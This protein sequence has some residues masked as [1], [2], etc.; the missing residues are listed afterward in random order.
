MCDCGC[1]SHSLFSQS[2]V[3][4]IKMPKTK[5]P[6]AAAAL[7]ALTLLATLA[8]PTYAF[9]TPYSPSVDPLKNNR[10][11]LTPSR[12]TAEAAS[13]CEA[14]PSSLNMLCVSSHRPSMALSLSSTNDDEDT[15]SV[16]TEGKANPK[17]TKSNRLDQL[18][19]QLTSAFPFFVLGQD[20]NRGQDSNWGQ[21]EPDSMVLNPWY[22]VCHNCGTK[23]CGTQNVIFG[24][25]GCSH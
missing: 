10:L 12:R 16:S 5:N 8:H 1:L 7:L 17:P 22:S 15:D 9:V 13:I 18:L 21:L 11:R 6:A 14:F 25:I 3:Q 2:C 20:S 24:Y 23:V 4:N 19:S